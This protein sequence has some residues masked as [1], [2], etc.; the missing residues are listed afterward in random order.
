QRIRE[1]AARIQC[2]NN[3]KQIGLACHAYHDANQGLPPGYTAAASFPSTSPGWGWAVYL[4]PYIE[5]ENLYR[6]LDFRQPLEGQPAVQSIVSIY[7]CPS[8]N[9]AAAPFALTDA[10]FA[11]S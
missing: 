11:T 7:L 8:D 2:A 1:V 5:Q 3:L 4:L 6:Q 10:T 9:P